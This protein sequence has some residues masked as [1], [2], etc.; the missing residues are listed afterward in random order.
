MILDELSRIYPSCDKGSWDYPSDP[1]S[2]RFN[3]P[4]YQVAHAHSLHS[5][6][7][8]LMMSDAD[9]AVERRVE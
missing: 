1:P 5:L 6:Y 9:H 3:R 8:M 4:W 7:D 2:G